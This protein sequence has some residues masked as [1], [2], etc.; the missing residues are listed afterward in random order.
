MK[1]TRLR[2]LWDNSKKSNIGK[3]GVSEAR[4]EERG[5]VKYSM[6]KLL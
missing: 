3:I 6:K 4:R 1:G 5:M 2:D